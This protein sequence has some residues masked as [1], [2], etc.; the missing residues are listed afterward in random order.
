MQGQAQSP[1]LNSN[2]DVVKEILDA[3]NKEQ[4]KVMPLFTDAVRKV[5]Y[6]QFVVRGHYEEILEEYFRTMMWLGRIDFWLTSPPYDKM[7]E[8]DI[9]RMSYAAVLLK[10]LLDLAKVENLLKVNEQVITFMVGESDNLTPDELSSVIEEIGLTEAEQLVI[11]SNTYEDF[12]AE[13]VSDERYA[14]KILSNVIIMDPLS[15]EPDKLP[16]S[17]KLMGQR[18]IIDSYIFSN[19][20]YDRIIFDDAKIW[21]P[22]PDPL[23]AMF[24]LG[25]N[26]A[27]P[28]L[29]DELNKYHYNQQLATLRYL[30][31][32][33]DDGFWESSIYNL[34]LNSIRKLNPEDENSNLPLFMKTDA[35]RMEK[36]NTQLASWAQLRHDNLLYA[37]QSYTGA[38]TCSYPYSYVEPYPEFYKHIATYA[39]KANEYFSQLDIEGFYT[40]RIEKYLDN[41]KTHSEFLAELAEKELSQIPFSR[42]E[43]N[44]LKKFLVKKDLLM[45]GEPPYD[46]WLMDLFYE[47]YEQGI[48][49]DFIV[50]DVHTQPTDRLGNIV[51][52]VLHVGLGYINMGVFLT[53]SPSNS[54]EYM[55]YIGPVM[56][57]YENITKDFDRFTDTRWKEM[58]KSKEITERPEWTNIYLA[59][60]DGNV[61]NK[62]KSLPFTEKYSY[63]VGL[64]PVET[65][66]FRFYPNPVN[67]IF[68]IKMN[69]EEKINEITLTSIDGKIVFRDFLPN[70]NTGIDIST[71]PK[72][73][74]ILKIKTSEGSYS[75]KVY[76]E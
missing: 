29:E 49:H 51:G 28:L 72:G 26:D 14:Q 19:V 15:P 13:L 69:G 71:L 38:A 24:V 64:S 22:M 30:V 42:E 48:K 60:N 21:R 45:C 35:W 5:D 37:K 62:M 75:D 20:V 2:S 54:Y 46:G 34:W 11:N 52:K 63:V 4:Y 43:L 39:A 6:S 57:Y 47:G 12:K 33:Y 74:Y 9:K 25:N 65:Q 73:I 53:P 44:K 61:K 59:D 18:F 36:I 10:E 3:I 8:K 27:L 16:V 70:D 23:D 31:D 56:S 41:L 17:F 50:A 66:D 55:A 58:I 1:Y 32:E 40:M 76:K 67:T 68:Q 7:P